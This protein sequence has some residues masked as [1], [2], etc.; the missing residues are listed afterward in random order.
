MCLLSIVAARRLFLTVACSTPAEPGGGGESPPSLSRGE[1]RSWGGGSDGRGEWERTTLGELE[2][3]PAEVGVG[4]RRSEAERSRAGSVDSGGRAPGVGVLPPV[5]RGKDQLRALTVCPSN[6]PGL[7]GLAVGAASAPPPPPTALL[8]NGTGVGPLLLEGGLRISSSGGGGGGSS[9]CW[10]RERRERGA[11]RGQGM[12][13]PLIGVGMS[14]SSSG[15][16]P[17]AGAEGGYSWEARSV[18][19][20]NSQAEIPP[21]SEARSLD[22]HDC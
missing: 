10:K 13:I 8:I 4:E 18:E 11:V 2:R 20:S 7:L 14:S 6:G 1:R 12:G 9:P 15:S 3:G 5:G 22:K 16:V 21:S 17:K 19:L